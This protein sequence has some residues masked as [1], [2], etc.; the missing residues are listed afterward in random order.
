MTTPAP[1]TDITEAQRLRAAGVPVTLA[2]GQVHHIRYDFAALEVLE[3]HFGTVS[4]ALEQAR[5]GRYGPLGR[6]LL[7]GLTHEGLSWEED[8]HLLSIH[9]SRTYLT[10]TAEAVAQAFPPPPKA[11]K[12]KRP[13]GS[14]KGEAKGG[15]PTTT[16]G[17]PGPGSSTPASSPSAAASESSGG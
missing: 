15:T 12:S 4:E 1:V 2:D 3:S 6:L 11:E 9:D 8:Q 7:A 10:V 5:S 17:S 16:G 13:K 14:A